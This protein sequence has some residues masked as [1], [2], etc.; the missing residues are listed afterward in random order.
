MQG[1]R[2]ERNQLT[3]KE[4]VLGPARCTPLGNVTQ[5]YNDMRTWTDAACDA[6]GSKILI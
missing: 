2:I 3:V 6:Y 4:P 1:R 5:V